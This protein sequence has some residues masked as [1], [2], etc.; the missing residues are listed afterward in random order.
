MSHEKSVKIFSEVGKHYVQGVVYQP[1][2]V[3]SHGE[4]FT[5]ADVQKMAYDFVSKGMSKQIDLMHNGVLCGAEVVESF[6]ARRGDPDYPENSWVMTVRLDEG[7]LW[8]AIKAGELNGFSLEAWVYKVAQTVLVDA[9]KIALGD[10]ELNNDP[11]VIEHHQHEF[12]VEFSDVGRVSYGVTN[13]V[14]GHIHQIIATSVTEFS[15]EHNHRWS[16]V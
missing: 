13:E 6:I 4:T 12:Y 16:I 8:D 5:V 2:S 3:D 1:L 14:L 15:D 11:L 9:V 10:T 7:P